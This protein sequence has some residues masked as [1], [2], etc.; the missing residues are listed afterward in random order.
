MSQD[1][2]LKRKL[3]SV[4]ISDI[5]PYKNNA[6]IHSPK[7]IESLIK[8]I[9][10]NEYLQPIAIDKNNTIVMGHGRYE[11][12]KQI[13]GKQ[14]IEVVDLGHLKPKQI[15]KLRIL[16]NKIVS[17]EWDKDILQKEIDDIYSGFDDLDKISDEIGIL[18][19]DYKTPDFEPGTEDEQGRL[20]KK[21]P[22]ICPKCKHEWIR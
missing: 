2:T 3:K 21:E 9:K 22:I 20:D 13:N 14:K 17:D 4:N 8:S 10:E 7:Q 6:K 5:K 15:K 16:D 12:I 18:P 19:E 11:A 1:F